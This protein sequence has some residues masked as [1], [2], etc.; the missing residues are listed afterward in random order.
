MEIGT[1]IFL[2]SLFLGTVALYI[3]TKN[4]WPWGRISKWVGATFLLVI[5]AGA[6]ALVWEHIKSDAQRERNLA[7]VAYADVALGYTIPDV[8]FRKGDPAEKHKSPDGRETWVYLVKGEYPPHGELGKVYVRFTKGE[9]TRVHYA[10]NFLAA[11]SLEGADYLS[12]QEQV[13]ERLGKP[14]SI[15]SSDDHKARILAYDARRIFYLLEQN[16]V[17]A[18]GIFDPKDGRPK[19]GSKRGE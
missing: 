8:L 18:R 7:Q 13:E 15:V 9:V 2:S 19:F 12:T 5:A 10:G 17:T 1:G 3:A 4:H 6:T 16:S 14:D 11:P